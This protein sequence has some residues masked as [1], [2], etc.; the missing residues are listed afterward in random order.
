MSNQQIA[1]ATSLSTATVERVIR[2]M[3]KECF[4]EVAMFQIKYDDGKWMNT[5]RILLNFIPPKEQ[6]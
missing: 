3:K 1:E 2:K 5:R 6:E 4:I